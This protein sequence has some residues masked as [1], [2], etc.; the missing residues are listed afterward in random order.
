MF[1]A[2]SFV[3]VAIFFKAM[4]NKKLLDL[5]FV[6]SGII[7]VSVGV[8]SLNTHLDLDYFGYLKNLI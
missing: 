3:F 8:I 4:Y 6:I 2:M 5:V 7:E 1:R